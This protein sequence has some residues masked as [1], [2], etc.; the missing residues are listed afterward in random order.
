MNQRVKIPLDK[1]EL[2]YL[3]DALDVIDMQVSRGVREGIGAKIR[4]KIEK[5][6]EMLENESRD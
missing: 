4:N 6:R 2:D 3:H 1:E 5:G